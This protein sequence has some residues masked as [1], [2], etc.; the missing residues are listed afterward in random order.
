M[1]DDELIKKIVNQEIF[2]IKLQKLFENHPLAMPPLTSEER[3]N[4]D[5]EWQEAIKR[6]L[7][8]QINLLVLRDERSK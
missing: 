6:G 7:H 5:A 3:A 8:E 4:Q 1:T 2:Q